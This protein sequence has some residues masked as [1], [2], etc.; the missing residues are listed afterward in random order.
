M[1]GRAYAR[2]P[3]CFQGVNTL[4]LPVNRSV[5]VAR[6]GSRNI[7]TDALNSVA[8]SLTKSPSDGQ[9]VEGH[10]P[11]DVV[12]FGLGG[13]S[14]PLY[15]RRRQK[16]DD[17]VERR[18]LLS[19]D[20]VRQLERRDALLKPYDSHFLKEM[21]DQGVV[22][23]YI[24]T[25]A[26]DMATAPWHLTARDEEEGAPDDALADGERLLEDIHP[27]K[28]FRDVLEMTARNMLTLGD[29]AWVKHY[30]SGT[31]ELAEAVPVDSSLFYKRV[32]RHGLTEGYIQV[33][34]ENQTAGEELD[35]EEMVWFEWSSR[36]GHVYGHGPVEK[37]LQQIELLDE[38]T[39]KEKQDLVE[40]MPP[41]IVSAQPP[42]GGALPD[43]EYEAIK[44]NWKLEE[45]ERHRAV[46]SRG[47]WDFTPLTPGYQDLQVLER[48][49]Y[50]VQ[51]LGAVFKV[52]SA[53]AGFDIEN[54]NRATHESEVEAYAQRGFRVLLRQ[55]EEAIN[56]QLIWTDVSEDVK[57]EFERQRTIQEQKA[58]AEFLQQL[59]TT[60]QEWDKAGRPVTFRDES[61]EIEEGEVEV[62]DEPAE[63]PFGPLEQEI[64]AVGDTV[65][66]ELADVRTELEAINLAKMD[67]M[68]NGHQMDPGEGVVVCEDTGA[69][70]AA[71]TF[72]DIDRECPAC[73]ERMA[74][75]APAERFHEESTA[76]VG[77]GKA[78]DLAVS[79]GEDSIQD[80][81]MEDWR[82]FLQ[83]VASLDGQ[84]EHLESGRTFPP[85]GDI[86]PGQGIVVHGL[87]GEV[88]ETLVA[89]Y[90]GLNY[91]VE[92]RHDHDRGAAKG[93][94]H[95]A[96]GA[97]LTK[98][99][100]VQLD[101][102]LLQVHETQIQPA[103]LD[104]IKKAAWNDEDSVPEFVKEKIADAIQDG[105]VFQDIEGIPEATVT[106]LE[107][108][109]GD[110]LTQSQGWSLRSL[111]DGMKD[112]WPGVSEDKLE[113]VARSETASV[114]NRARELGYEDSPDP[115][116]FKFKW[117][118]PNDSRTTLACEWL[119]GGDGLAGEGPSFDGTNPRHGGE[120][121]SMPE[122][123]SREEQATAEFFPNLSHRKHMVHPNER[124]TFVRSVQVPGGG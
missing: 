100:A 9:Y 87:E 45:G 64:E 57:F 83:D 120:P 62:E 69:K 21:A 26:Q 30:H 66:T 36:P 121:V 68:A 80:G 50:W 73:G 86:P 15:T 44:N 4:S 99:Q 63:G 55:M 14:G 95:A 82:G 16:Q 84:V 117:N 35:L 40:G 59:A 49:K 74:V 60:A 23:A 108:F 119:K 7:L 31:G 10:G 17:D 54:V 93:Y 116:R 24:D 113:V 56:R 65:E 105:A 107:D 103:A 118:G 75:Q 32:T 6:R 110:K 115:E 2:G 89:R 79:R 77:Q 1:R 98:E 11:G 94:D 92:P 52:N 48:S 46:V 72:Q 8:K 25:L 22:Q 101:E 29:G 18:A 78:V 5:N 43:D 104:D 53:Y 12:P 85:D 91:A 47:Q 28:S 76:T 67:P 39:E 90:D 51:V 106:R 20:L 96:E 124:H 61:L 13:G 112:I 3:T 81:G 41:G 58:H 38:L 42:E 102:F 97:G 70:F 34:L 37:A 19:P 27:E 122:L 114:L 109:L 33:S 88:V 111:V 71:E 123:L